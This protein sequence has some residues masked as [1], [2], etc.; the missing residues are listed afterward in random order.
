MMPVTFWK[1]TGVLFVVGACL[2][3]ALTF[4]PLGI[5]VYGNK[6][7]LNLSFTT[8]KPA[9]FMKFAM[10]MHMAALVVACLQQDVPQEGESKHMPRR[11]CCM[12]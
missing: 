2:L 4:T 10:C 6:G 9:E 12:R 5:D 1:R 3:R 8:I 11:W 7:W